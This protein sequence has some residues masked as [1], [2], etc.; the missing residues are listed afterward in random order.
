MSGW[1]DFDDE[2]PVRASQAY[3]SRSLSTLSYRYPAQTDGT[4]LA[5][6][7]RHH[8]FRHIS[9]RV[10]P[11]GTDVCQATYAGARWR[12]RGSAGRNGGG[13]W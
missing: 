1:P 3:Q 5:P 11:K 2:T 13:G 10:S 7:S 9:A 4:A 12:R 8:H 6:G